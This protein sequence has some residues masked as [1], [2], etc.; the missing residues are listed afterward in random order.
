MEQFCVEMVTCTFIVNCDFAEYD[1]YVCPHSKQLSS[2]MNG[3]F[4]HDLSNV[5]R[6]YSDYQAGLSDC[7]KTA[8]GQTDFYDGYHSCTH[9]QLKNNSVCCSGSAACH[10]AM[11]IE[12]SENSNSR[13]SFVRC[14]GYQACKNISNGISMNKARGGTVHLGSYLV[15]GFHGITIDAA[16][17]GDIVCTGWA[18]CY[19]T[20]ANNLYCNAY[21]SCSDTIVSNITNVYGYGF[22]G[23]GVMTVVG[24]VEN[25]YCGTYACASGDINNVNNHL[26]CYGSGSLY[27]GSIANVKNVFVFGYEAIYHTNITNVTQL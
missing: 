8:N 16:G 4:L 23:A 10:N 26:Y 14:D 24:N 22:V 7:K 13:Y 25:V 9:Q 11:S 18:S 12:I 15:S 3:K 19:G 17:D 6:K 27:S 1:E 20:N 2:F 21:W 5:S